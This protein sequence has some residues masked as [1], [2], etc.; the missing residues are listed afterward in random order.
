MV[1]PGITRTGV[2]FKKIPLLILEIEEGIERNINVREK[3]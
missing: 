1:S 3:H 2:T